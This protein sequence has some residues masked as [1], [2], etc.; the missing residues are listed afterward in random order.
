MAKL[1]IPHKV[2]VHFFCEMI[3]VSDVS[4]VNEPN[5]I[6]YDFLLKV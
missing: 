1:M 5:L 2:Y 6:C 3:C 4:D